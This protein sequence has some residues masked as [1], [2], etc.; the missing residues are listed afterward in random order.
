MQKT[1]RRV[2]LMVVPWV[3]SASGESDSARSSRPRRPRVSATTKI[4]HN[5]AAARTT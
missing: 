2:R 3:S 5:T 4:E 1:R